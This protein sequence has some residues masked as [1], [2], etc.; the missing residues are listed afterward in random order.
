MIAVFRNYLPTA[1]LLKWQHEGRKVLFEPCRLRFEISNFKSEIPLRVLCA[2][3]A[4][5][6]T[7]HLSL[8]TSVNQPKSTL[9]NP[10]TYRLHTDTDRKNYTLCQPVQSC[11]N[12]YKT[13]W[14]GEG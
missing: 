5:L 9:P 12:L 11:T 14:R 10:N 3:V 7:R 1:S 6:I 8:V 13:P 4:R 2:S